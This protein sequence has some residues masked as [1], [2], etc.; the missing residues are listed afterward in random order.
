MNNITVYVNGEQWVIP[1]SKTPE[2]IN[3]LRQNAHSTTNQQ[4]SVLSN[5]MQN[6]P[7]KKLILES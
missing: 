1:S 3:W 7:N 6:D 4:P 2:F 5:S